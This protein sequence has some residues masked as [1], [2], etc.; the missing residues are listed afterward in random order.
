MNSFMIQ[1]LPKIEL[2][3]SKFDLFLEII[4]WVLFVVFWIW[5]ILEYFN[6]PETI[7]THFNFQGE[8]DSYGSKSSLFLLPAF[9]TFIFIALSWINRY[10]H[11]FNYPVKITE[12]NAET[13]YRIATRLMRIMKITVQTSFMLIFFIVIQSI[14]GVENYN[15]LLITLLIFIIIIAPVVYFIMKMYNSAKRNKQLLIK[16]KY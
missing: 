11:I 10:P 3:L 9:S 12:E 1:K 6:L 5:I 15:I 7:P 14:N 8:I 2:K 13:Q 4:G 16:N